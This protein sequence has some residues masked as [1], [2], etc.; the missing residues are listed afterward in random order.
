VAHD[1]NHLVLREVL[2]PEDLEDRF[3]SYAE[4]Q[5]SKRSEAIR[6]LV[7]TGL[8]VIEDGD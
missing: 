3:R 1:S 7:E 5:L 8:E 6:T 2:L 4:S